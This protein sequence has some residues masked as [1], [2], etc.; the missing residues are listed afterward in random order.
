MWLGNAA[1]NRVRAYIADKPISKRYLLEDTIIEMDKI[2]R[3][4][5]QVGEAARRQERAKRDAEAKQAQRAYEKIM[6]FRQ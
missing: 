4:T 6:N 5:T 3:R 2:A 1:A